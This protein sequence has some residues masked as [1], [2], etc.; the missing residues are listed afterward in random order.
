MKLTLK[1][2]KIT[3]ISVSLF[4]IVTIVLTALSLVSTNAEVIYKE[5]SSLG[6]LDFNFKH[7]NGTALQ[8]N[9]VPT[10]NLSYDDSTGEYAIKTNS[11]VM[12]ETSD[13]IS[14]AYRWYHQAYGDQ[15]KLVIETEITSHQPE[16]KNDTMHENASIGIALRSADDM[17]ARSIFLHLRSNRIG[18]VWRDKDGSQ[19]G[20]VG[21]SKTIPYSNCPVF[22]KIEL[23]G[24]AAR[25]SVKV[26][27]KGD[28]KS[29]ATHYI[30]LGENI[31]AG[32]AAHSCNK[33]SPIL[34]KF[35]DFKVYVEG[36]SGSKYT[37]VGDKDDGDDDGKDENPC[38]PDPEVTDGILFRETFTDGSMTNET[39]F[40]GASTQEEIEKR[41]IANPIW[42]DE[43]SVDG[44]IKNA[45]I[46]V[47]DDNRYWHRNGSTDAY[48]FANK[49]WYDYSYSVDLKFGPE[50]SEDG[51]NSVDL[52]TRFKANRNN[53]YFGYRVSM[54]KNNTVEIRKIYVTRN[55]K[56]SS[57]RSYL[58]SKATFNY[59]KDGWNTWR[60]DA[61]DNKISVYCNDELVTEC[62]DNDLG[63]YSVNGSGGIGIGSSGCDL[64][65]DNMAV[66]K[67]TDLLGGDFDNKIGGN[68]DS[69]VP[70]Y[71]ENYKSTIE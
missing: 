5:D 52:Y 12:W 59:L 64:M 57:N 17:S 1:N 30:D 43:Y 39:D 63:K 29:F 49:E 34:S 15:G 62:V 7:Y 2:K 46:G 67:L 65:V 11:F 22:L 42:S 55:Q 58:C 3:L 53:G 56:E 66:T 54:S 14:Y 32:I 16:N 4:L 9:Y 38:P 69:P 45:V 24:N 28:W 71:I 40:S 25:C 60:I 41:K 35:K 8:Q 10:G 20:W 19:T 68:W 13:N 36:P 37:P 18:I 31:M 48:F 21:D 47:E 23:Q 61:F 33:N 70:D 27:E 6:K 44:N 26:G 50:T 51:E